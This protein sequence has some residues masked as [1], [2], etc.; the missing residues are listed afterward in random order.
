[1]SIEALHTRHPILVLGMHRSGTSAAT[2]VLN[3]LGVDLGSRLMPA[4]PDNPTGFWEH[5]DVVD[6]HE[7]LLAAFGMAWD[8]VRALPPGWLEHPATAEAATAI[9]GLVEREFAASP[10]WA[11]KDPR[12]CRFVPLWRRVL[13]EL[14]QQPRALFVLRDPAEVAHSLARRNGM[15]DPMGQLLWARHLVDAVHGCKGLPT[16]AL[17]YD[18]LLRD[19]KPVMRK[20][21]RDLGL[22]LDLD[23]AEAAHAIEAFLS[24]QLRH[25]RSES[26]AGVWAPIR[27]L[28]EAALTALPRVRTVPAGDDLLD[29]VLGDAAPVVR[30]VSQQLGEARRQLRQRESEWVAALREVEQR[31]RWALEL[32]GQ[33]A[34]AHRHVREAQS[35]HA[36]AVDWA[37]SLDAELEQARAQVKEAQSAHAEAVAWAKSLDA[38]LEQTR[39]QFAQLVAHHEEVAAWAKRLDGE[40]DQTRQ[41]FARLAAQHEAVESRAKSLGAEL[42]QTRRELAEL[43]VEHEGVASWAKSLDAELSATRAE[44]ADTRRRKEHMERLVERVLQQQEAAQR[45]LA[46]NQEALAETRVALRVAEAQAQQFHVE[47][48]RAT[49][50][51]RVLR[52]HTQQLEATLQQMQRSTSWRL[53]RPLRWLLAWLRRTEPEVRLPESPRLE[54]WGDVPAPWAP[55]PLPAAGASTAGRDPR[56]E[57]LDFPLVAQPEVTIVIPTYGKLDYTLACLRSIRRLPDRA[58]FEV[59]VLED[60]SGEPDMDLLA[61]VPGLRYH[62]NPENLGFLRSCNQAA[63]LAR[64]RYICFLNNDTEVQPGWLDALLDVARTHADAGIVGSKLVYP[65]GRLQEAGGIVWRDASAWNYGRLGDPDAHEFNYV[66]RVDYVS[67]ASLLIATGLFRELGGFDERYAPAYCEDSDLAFRVRER[68]LEVYYTPFSVVIHH[69][70]VSHGTDVQAGVKAYQVTNQRR[71][72]ERWAAHLAAHYPNGGNVLRARDRAWNRPLV[73]VVD[74]YIPQPDRDAGSR[75]MIA[76]LRELVEAGCVVKFWPENLHLDPVYAPALMRM[77]IEVVHGPRWKGRFAE[78]MAEVGPELDAV[79]LSR[80]H[81]AAPLIATIRRHSQA[82]LVYYGHDLHYRRLE[83]EARVNGSEAA[84]REAQHMQRL[85]RDVWRRVDVVLYPSEEEA[86]HVRALEP[87]TDARAISP[88]AF[89]AVSQPESAGGR[90]G[91][92]F[93][94]GFAHPPNVDAAEWLVRE[95]MP[96]VWREAPEVRLALVG[97]N[98]SERVRAL[99]DERVEVTGYV[100]DEELEQRYAA[101]R[102]AVVPLRFG[103][104]V[105]NKVV[106]AMRYGVPLVTTGVGAQGLPG[107]EATATVADTAEGVAEGLLTLL[108]DDVRWVE[109]SR[110]GTRY[111]RERFSRAAMRN[112]LVEALGIARSGVPA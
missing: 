64:G 36:E 3:L 77:G 55:L 19:W 37:K 6:L 11:V 76:F 112:V 74:H 100:S 82:P 39:Q 106:E 79:L 104:G 94:A 84:S 110:A 2:R 41:Q 83:D 92:L 21:A 52:A 88:Y 7:Q 40:L 109:A 57:G 31:S 78:F 56:I 15:P 66:R 69:E 51:A 49:R 35:A 99:G 105:K 108:R 91:A 68:G 17:A 93:V 28:A 71:F 42:E 27:P 87:G 46:R 12:L 81:V 80:P 10:R 4:G 54:G 43:L 45:E 26:L 60:A 24:P 38:E 67:G 34:E 101:A 59:V 102:V 97:A 96:L 70:G 75:T 47:L 29:R 107:L 1:M 85:E 65:D 98:P 89:D 8:D 33:L 9:R 73:L 30:A 53:T 44:L 5:Q 72:H 58:S 32:E 25:H 23:S 16:A 103:A 13:E 111:V 48:A 18:E 61:A 50:E 62:P 95:V 20:V 14:G 86:A 90:Q 22:R 63:G